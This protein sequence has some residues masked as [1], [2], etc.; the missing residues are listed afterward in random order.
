MNDQYR[1]NEDE[2]EGNDPALM[3]AIESLDDYIRRYGLLDA[4]GGESTLKNWR[5]SILCCVLTLVGFVRG[6]ASMVVR[7]RR[8]RLSPHGR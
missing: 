3:P 8:H 2:G 4:N 7:L 6:H 5:R 1:N